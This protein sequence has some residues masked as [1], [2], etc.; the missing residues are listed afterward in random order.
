MRPQM[1][2][3]RTRLIPLSQRGR[4]SLYLVNPLPL[5]FFN[6]TRIVAAAR[7]PPPPRHDYVH[8]FPRES[9]PAV[10]RAANVQRVA[11]PSERKTA[12]QPIVRP[13]AAAP[14]ALPPSRQRRTPR[15]PACQEASAA[16]AAAAPRAS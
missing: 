6:P 12:L 15:R 10:A 16:R 9:P 13:Q 4:I 3:S 11:P 14:T 8:V 5:T 7:V 1:R 2:R